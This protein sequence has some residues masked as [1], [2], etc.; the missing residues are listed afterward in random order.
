MLMHA[1]AHGGCTNTIRESVLEVYSGEKKIPC[2]TG[3]SSPHQYC[4][5]AFRS[6]SPSAALSRL[7]SVLVPSHREVDA[8]FRVYVIVIF[9]VAHLFKHTC[10]AR[11]L[12]CSK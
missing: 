2:R 4:H 12:S 8:C 1:I 10:A 3:D 9:S 11:A 7:I 5:L 6:D